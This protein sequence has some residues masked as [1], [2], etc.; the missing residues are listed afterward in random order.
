MNPDRFHLAV[1]T[2]ALDPKQQARIYPPF[3][4]VT[5]ELVDDFDNAI[6][7]GEFEAY[8]KTLSLEQKTAL[9]SLKDAAQNIPDEDWWDPYIT[10]EA[11]L[12]KASWVKVRLRAQALLKALGVELGIVP[13]S[14]QT[15]P[16]SWHRK[17]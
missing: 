8:A 10:I 1:R 3:V 5:Y 7:T 15:K 13:A 6:T 12:A 9:D 2:L 17:P 16:G 14:I 4:D 11:V